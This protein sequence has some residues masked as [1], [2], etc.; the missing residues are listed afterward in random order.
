MG[1]PSVDNHAW[2]DI[3]PLFPLI[4]PGGT[5]GTTAQGVAA[6]LAAS[7]VSEDRLGLA[8]TIA[9]LVGLAAIQARGCLGRGL[10]PVSPTR[11]AI[12]GHSLGGYTAWHLALRSGVPFVGIVSFSGGLPLMPYYSHYPVLA[13]RRLR[14]P[15]V[16]SVAAGGDIIVGTLVS[17]VA[18]VVGRQLLGGDE[19]AVRHTTLRGSGHSSYLIGDANSRRVRRVKEGALRGTLVDGSG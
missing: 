8:L 13:P 11:T 5:N 19:G 16:A 3:L 10:P 4:A 14:R 9:R 7:P 2:F 1:I 6:E 15:P 12:A 18:V 17:E